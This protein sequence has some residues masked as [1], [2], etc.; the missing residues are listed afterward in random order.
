[1]NQTSLLRQD[2]TSRDALPRAADVRKEHQRGRSSP[3]GRAKS[4]W[5]AGSLQACHRKRKRVNDL[6]HKLLGVSDFRSFPYCRGLSLTPD[7]RLQFPVGCHATCHSRELVFLSA[8][9]PL[10]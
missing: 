3:E 8:M 7:M 10:I 5:E 9:P 6:K 2:F 4:G 1:M